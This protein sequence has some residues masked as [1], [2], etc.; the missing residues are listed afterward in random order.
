MDDGE[1]IFSEFLLGCGLGTLTILLIM[2]DEFPSLAS[3][4]PFNE[5]K[6]EPSEPVSIGNH[7]CFDAS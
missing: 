7:N 1:K 3:D 4:D 2:Y 5:F 6:G